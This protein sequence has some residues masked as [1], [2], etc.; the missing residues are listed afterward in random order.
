[1]DTKLSP[2]KTQ[3]SNLEALSGLDPALLPQ[4]VAFIM[5]GNGR[6]ASHRGQDRS[7]GHKAG[8][9]TVKSM[10]KAFLSWGLPHMTLY[11]FST[12]NWKRPRQEVN[13]LMHLFREVIRR[14]C[15]SLKAQGVRLR[16]LGDRQGLEGSV[17]EMMTWS[18]RETADN[19]RLQ[20]NIAL[21]YGGRDELVRASRQLALAVSQGKLAPEAIEESHLEAFLD[22]AGQPDPDLVIRTS[23]EKRL[24]NFLLW[25]LA[26]AEIYL[27]DTHWPDFREADLQ[28]ALQAYAARQ[29]R[30]GG[31]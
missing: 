25:Q 24:S 6:W 19:Q 3:N 29:R 10:V 23:G 16:F 9:Q 8:V 14:E 12:E 5:D 30:F 11:A 27:T 2:P 1:M 7:I 26:Y 15:A 22:T 20:L 17:I 28:Q 31:C 21:N 13:F 4:H 18:E